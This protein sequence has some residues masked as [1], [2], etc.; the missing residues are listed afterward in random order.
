MEDVEISLFGKILQNE[1]EEECQILVSSIKDNIN[2]ILL[3]ILKA[4]YPYKNNI[5]LNKM[6]NK[7]I[8]NEIPPEKIQQIIESL[9]DEKGK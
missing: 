3:N 9:Y 6:K 8:K 5:D 7:Y 2:Y 4:E 1:L